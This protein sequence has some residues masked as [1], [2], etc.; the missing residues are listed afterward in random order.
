M[1]RMSAHCAAATAKNGI[2]T[3]PS[4]G[5]RDCM[6]PG[7]DEFLGAVNNVAGADLRPLAYQSSRKLELATSEY[8]GRRSDPIPPDH[9]ERHHVE[10]HQLA[11]KR[12]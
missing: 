5:A 2:Q 4:D 12:S 6:P 8:D 7:S 1:R 3:R 9:E 11:E 10:S